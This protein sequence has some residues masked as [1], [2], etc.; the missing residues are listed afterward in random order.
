MSGDT[1]DYLWM[2]FV[3]SGGVSAVNDE[4]KNFQLLFVFS[5]FLKVFGGTE[6]GRHAGR[7]LVATC[8]TRFPQKLKGPHNM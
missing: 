2:L 6:R 8:L 4:A 3:A 7:W 1:I 5:E